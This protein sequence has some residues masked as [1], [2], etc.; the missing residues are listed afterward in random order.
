MFERIWRF[1]FAVK[2]FQFSCA[3]GEGIVAR[4]PKVGQELNHVCSCGTG[5]DM[6]W[7][8]VQFETR[9]VN[10]LAANHAKA[11]EEVFAHG[12]KSLQAELLR[13]EFEDEV[14]HE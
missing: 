12:V 13:G 1:L 9:M 14:A 10:P 5:W 7:T 3:C 8:G 2:A 6:K 11:V 4:I